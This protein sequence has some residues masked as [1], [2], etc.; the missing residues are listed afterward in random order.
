LTNSD[1]R[2]TIDEG[3][4]RSAICEVKIDRIHLFV[5]RHSSFIIRNSLLK[6]SLFEGFYLTKYCQ[7]IK[8][9]FSKIC[10]SPS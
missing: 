4:C 3:W 8:F 1:F 10:D 5:T 9:S 6:G 2:L 7:K